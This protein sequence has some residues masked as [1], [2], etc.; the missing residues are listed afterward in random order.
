M[1]GNS[2]T[3]R[4]GVSIVLFV[5][6]AFATPGRAAD[7]KSF[8]KVVQGYADTMIDQVRDVYGPKK[9][10]LLL[11]AYDRINMKPL[12][13]RPCPPGG[14]RR[15]DRVG[16]PWLPLTGSNPQL[17][18]NLLRVFYTLSEL[19]GDEKYRQA[20]D[21]ELKW[22]L[23]N[24]QSPATGLLP[25]GEHLCWC[26]MTDRAIS[27]HGVNMDH[28]FAR[29]WVLWDR[30]YELAPV[31]SKRFALG[32]WNHQIAN[33][34]TGGFDRHA[35]YD[36][37]GPRD[38]SDFARHAGFY[39][40]TWGYA[41]K[42][43][44]DEVFLKA[45]ET[46]VNRFDKIKGFDKDGNKVATMGPLDVYTASTMVPDPLATRLRK[47][48]EREDE[49]ML[50]SIKE[51]KKEK[52]FLPTAIK[53]TWQAGYSSGVS[54]S[55]AMFYLARYEQVSRK[56]HRDL[57]VEIA[58]A[59]LGT[60]PAED[61]D[62][63]PM[64]V[65]HVIATQVAAYRFTGKD[66]YLKEARKFA[67]MAVDIYWQDSPLPRAGLK[68]GHYETISGPDTLA[69]ALLDVHAAMYG[70]KTPIPLNTIDR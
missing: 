22:F 25:W 10:G 23:N 54:A 55:R 46:L 12:T 18:Q 45:I 39:I 21:A 1:I 28:E 6:F 5:M 44:K 43:T 49:L 16:L 41:Y 38:H 64:S 51:Q 67:Q 20:A 11:S 59:Y 53:A 34:E 68:I 69:L 57:L 14:V 52:G 15:G 31:A 56:E 19:T 29:P 17:D 7:E 42:H 35:L 48:A 32:L 8:L 70:I 3:L 62:V 30:C 47:F 50:K 65:G 60:R 33:H 27:A 24:T 66:V 63:W 2:R 9:S 61:V 13:T 36:K 58:D 37:H 26:V 4:A 40:H